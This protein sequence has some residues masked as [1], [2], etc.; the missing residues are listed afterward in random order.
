MPSRHI[1][2]SLPLVALVTCGPAACGS[3]SSPPLVLSGLYV[4]A[5]DDVAAYIFSDASH[6]AI[7]R[8]APCAPSAVCEE[9]GTYQADFANHTVTFVSHGQTRTL[10]LQVASG[11]AQSTRVAA[12]TDDHGSLIDSTGTLLACDVLIGGTE[13][14]CTRTISY[15]DGVSF[16]KTAPCPTFAGATNISFQEQGSVDFD[17]ASGAH[18]T[19]KG[20][21]PV[22]CPNST[23]ASAM[24]LGRVDQTAGGCK[25]ELFPQ[26]NENGAVWCYLGSDGQGGLV[27]APTVSYEIPSP[28]SFS[29]PPSDAQARA[30]IISKYPG[31]DPQGVVPRGLLEDAVE[32]FDINKANIPNQKY[33]TIVDYSQFSGDDRF[34][35]LDMG[36]GAVEAHKVAHGTGTDPDNIGY[37]T[38]FSNVAGSLM[39]SLGFYLGGE[40]YTDTYPHSMRLDGLS[41]DGSPNDMA[42]TNARQREVVMHR[43]TLVSDS[44]SGQQGLSEGCPALDP[45]IEQSVVD[46]LAYGSLIYVQVKPLN[47]P[48]GPLPA[49]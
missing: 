30:Q 48:V 33:I 31:L 21:Q 19:I 40:I 1:P 17:D 11:D 39:S 24:D 13:K 14:T 47:P 10:S 41:P 8:R 20:V 42:T 34:F 22:A 5:G 49:R 4:G 44:N 2:Y 36:S 15:V 46:R 43:Y 29:L 27:A 9:E 6:Y 28:S 23:Y 25:I 18:H 38:V 12:L 35:I 16:P 45:A 3:S 32:F 37:A 26:E 7:V